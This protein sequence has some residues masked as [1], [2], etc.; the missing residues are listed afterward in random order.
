MTDRPSTLHQDLLVGSYDCVDQIVLNAY[1]RMGHDPG[2]FRVWWRRKGDSNSRSHPDG[3]LSQRVALV[4]ICDGDTDGA[5][6]TAID[7]GTQV[8]TRLAASGTRARWGF[9]MAVGAALYERLVYAEDGGFITGS[10]L[11]YA[12]PT[13]SSWRSYIRRPRRR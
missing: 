1:F 9:A 5:P 11:D 10:L 6:A 12:L 7:R 3:E 8:R 4:D 2:G 13:A